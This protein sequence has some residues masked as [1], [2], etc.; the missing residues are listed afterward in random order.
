MRRSDTER[1]RNEAVR[2]VTRLMSAT[3]VAAAIA[4]ASAPIV[5][6]AKPA[7]THTVTYAARELCVYGLNRA[8]PPPHPLFNIAYEKADGAI[9]RLLVRTANWGTAL[10]G[11]R[12]GSTFQLRLD[13]NVTPRPCALT[14]LICWVQV[15]GVDVVRNC[16]NFRPVT[17][18]GPLP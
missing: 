6:A 4:W 9:T 18:A 7:G 5:A 13:S 3:A 8:G 1:Q 16:G 14:E 10:N 17:C 2:H 15:D 12:S 11:F